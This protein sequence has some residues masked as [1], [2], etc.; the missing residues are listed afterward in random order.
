M[1]SVKYGGIVTEIKG[2]LGGTVFQKSKSGGTAKNK[3]MHGKAKGFGRST[4]S[5]TFG[6]AT[7]KNQKRFASIT[8]MW[9]ALSSVQKS[10]WS[11]LATSWTFKN[12][13][14][15][16]YT[17]SG[18]QVFCAANLNLGILGLPYI[19]DAPLVHP[20]VEIDYTFGD[21]EISGSFDVSYTDLLASGQYVFAQIFWYQKIGTPFKNRKVAGSV[22]YLLTPPGTTDFKPVVDNFFGGTPPMGSEFYIALWSCWADYPLQQFH[23]L[24]KINVNP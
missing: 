1:A 15:E 8:K 23:S 19:Q 6:D 2:K 24:Q 9:Q 7:Q 21:Y 14:G 4:N 3:G 22:P 11:S 20:G 5:Q 13:F 16:V 18:Y 17:A 12:K 10:N